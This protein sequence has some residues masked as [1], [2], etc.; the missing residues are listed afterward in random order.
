M[1]SR[2]VCYR[3]GGPFHISHCIAH[4]FVHVFP[5]IQHRSLHSYVVPSVAS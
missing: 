4:S 5:S 3:A 2:F 1:K